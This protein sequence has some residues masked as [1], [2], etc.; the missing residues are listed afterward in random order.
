MKRVALFCALLLCALAL[1]SCAPQTSARSDAAEAA[2]DAQTQPQQSALPFPVGQMY[3]LHWGNNAFTR[4][5][6]SDG[7]AYYELLPVCLRDDGFGGLE[8]D[9]IILRTDFAGR[10]QAPLCSL[11]GCMHTDASCPAYLIPD[12]DRCYFSMELIEGQLYVQH[13]VYYIDSGAAAS[14]QQPVVYLE[15]VNLD[16]SGRE[17]LA[18]L[19][20]GW[21]E[22]NFLLCDGAALYGQYIDSRAS[23]AYSVRVDLATGEYTTFSLGL[24]DSEQLA[25]SLGN[26][27]LILRSNEYGAFQAAYP[28]VMG[29]ERGRVFAATDRAASP[30]SVLLL[31]PATGARTNL[32]EHFMGVTPSVYTMVQLPQ[33]GFYSLLS[34]PDLQSQTLWQIDPLCGEHRAL[35]SFTPPLSYRSGSLDPFQLFSS[36]S[37][38]VEPY[39]CVYYWDDGERYILIGVEDGVLHEIA[40]SCARLDSG[41]RDALPLAQTDDGMWLVPV[42]QM[43]PQFSEQRYA[44]ALAS[45]ET[46]FSGAGD[47]QPIQ[48]WDAPQALG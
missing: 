44:Y 19:P 31:D 17:R 32:T 27:F 5:G 47:V 9:W 16:G 24:D 46:V 15:R 28:D 26:Q 43:E 6:C 18:E 12:S 34:Y 45:P 30:V 36:G 39:L 25:G 41:T 11:P 2:P 37:D 13:C 8:R 42:R 7:Q 1:V 40:L 3:P 29:D 4:S 38:A 14:E 48:M 20:F 23:A 33:G 21:I 22:G 10:T 35:A